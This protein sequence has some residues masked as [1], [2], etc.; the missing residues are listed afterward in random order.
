MAKSSVFDRL[1]NTETYASKRLK[2]K[3]QV[4]EEE[5]RPLYNIE[6]DSQSKS[7][8]SNSLVPAESMDSNTS[9]RSRRSTTSKIKDKTSGNFDK[10]KDKR[11]QAEDVL[12]TYGNGTTRFRM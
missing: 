5:G 9:F 11:F 1:S 3:K 8:D 10:K 2:E 12:R 7:F 6:V 4:V